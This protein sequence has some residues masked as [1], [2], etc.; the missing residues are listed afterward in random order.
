MKRLLLPLALISFS[1]I[2]LSIVHIDNINK[3]DTHSNE[4]RKKVDT[5]LNTNSTIERRT[6]LSAPETK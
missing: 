2:S 3:L 6:T 5:E 1:V 4:L